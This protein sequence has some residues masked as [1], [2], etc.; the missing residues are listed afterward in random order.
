MSFFLEHSD[1]SILPDPK[2]PTQW[3]G[4]AKNKKGIEAL[5]A[6]WGTPLDDPVYPLCVFSWQPTPAALAALKAHFPDTKAYHAPFTSQYH[7]TWLLQKDGAWLT[8][9]SKPPSFSVQR[10]GKKNKDTLVCVDG[11][12]HHDGGAIWTFKRTPTARLNA[13]NRMHHNLT[14]E[15]WRLES[16][17]AKRVTITF[18]C[19]QEEDAFKGL[20]ETWRSICGVQNGPLGNAYA[21]AKHAKD[22]LWVISREDA[23]AGDSP[24][25]APMNERLFRAF[26]EQR[27][28]FPLFSDDRTD[29]PITVRSLSLFRAVAHTY[30]IE[31]QKAAFL[32]ELNA[33]EFIPHREKDLDILFW[34]VSPRAAAEQW[35]DNK[36]HYDCSLMYDT[37]LNALHRTIRQCF[38]EEDAFFFDELARATTSQGVAWDAVRPPHDEPEWAAIFRVWDI[39]QGFSQWQNA[40]LSDEGAQGLRRCVF[41]LCEETQQPMSSVLS[42]TMRA[43]FDDPAFLAALDDTGFWGALE[44]AS[45]R[46][47]EWE[48]LL[49]RH[50]LQ[51]LTPKAVLSGA[52]PRSKQ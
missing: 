18:H 48:A 37:A 26:F 32:R 11:F 35:A 38:L 19:E 13:F 5:L 29:F 7:E 40:P 16:P 33:R 42:P 3:R 34:C 45:T 21:S 47:P 14:G 41:A 22:G 12:S 30:P 51:T 31:T 23:Y 1:F 52:K 10:E 44:K 25:F 6:L 49:E 2:D 15:G 20:V 46:H 9:P 39:Q 43:A 27:V 8:W 17:E 24:T 4:V 50:L 28:S 36:G